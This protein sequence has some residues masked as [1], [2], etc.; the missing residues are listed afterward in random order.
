MRTL[1]TGLACMS[2]DLQWRVYE[3]E[4][5]PEVRIPIVRCV[6]LYHQDPIGNTVYTQAFP[7]GFH[8]YT[9]ILI[10]ENFMV[11]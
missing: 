8:L 1:V 2:A 5:T 9:S 4:E 6:C 7:D 10:R 3:L 11:A